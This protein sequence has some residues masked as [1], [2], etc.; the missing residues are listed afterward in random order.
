LAPVCVI[1]VYFGIL[2]GF[3]HDLASLYGGE[4][5]DYNWDWGMWVGR[6]IFGMFWG[7]M[8]GVSA[9]GL[10]NTLV[11]PV[12]VFRQ[13]RNHLVKVALGLNLVFVGIVLLLLAAGI[14][15]PEEVPFSHWV[16]RALL[17][18][19]SFAGVLG[20]VFCLAIPP[21]SR[22]QGVLYG[23]VALQIGV[24]IIRTEEYIDVAGS[25]KPTDRLS[26]LLSVASFLLF[27]VFLKRLPAYVEAPPLVTRAKSLLKL[28]QQTIILI[29][30]SVGVWLLTG[31]DLR[32]TCV[33]VMLL[34]ILVVLFK[35][36]TLIRDLY[37]VILQ[38]L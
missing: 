32:E 20:S 19:A 4:P 13:T 31:V 1:L 22:A 35:F 3:E 10:W 37:P 8:F 15:I 17:A 30:V 16:P 26:V 6:V 18:L 36:F 21:K 24:L 2:P 25:G 11:I 5:Q 9:A 7:A 14:P 28:I 29:G 33:K 12:W 38:K 34:V 23:S 27:V